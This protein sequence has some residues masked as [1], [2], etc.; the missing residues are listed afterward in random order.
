[1]IK[2]KKEIVYICSPYRGDIK[3]N[4]QY[5]RELT[6]KA[7]DAGYTPITPHLYL[8]EVL[9]D[10]KEIERIKGLTAGL[11]LLRACD[12]ILIGKK[13]GISSGMITEIET[14]K[15]KNIKELDLEACYEKE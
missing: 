15:A 7:L 11:T 13:Y 1:M 12:K 6:K 14:A 10:D 9:D 4:K 3:R 5:A 8:T 2:F